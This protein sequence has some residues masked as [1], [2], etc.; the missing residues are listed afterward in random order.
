VLAGSVPIL[1]VSWTVLDC[2]VK[3]KKRWNKR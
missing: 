2:L 1:Q 3:P